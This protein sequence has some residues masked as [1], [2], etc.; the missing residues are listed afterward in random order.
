[1]QHDVVER[2]DAG[3]ARR[4]RRRV[5][6]RCCLARVLAGELRLERRDTARRARACSCRSPTRRS[7]TVSAPSGIS[8]STPFRLCSR[9][10]VSVS[11]RGPR[12]RRSAARG[13]S[14][15]P[16]RYCPVSGLS[17][18]RDIGPAKT[19]LAPLLAARRARAPP[20]NRRRGSPR[21]RARRRAPCCRRRAAA[22]AAR[23]AG[24]CRAGAAR[25][26]ARRARTACRRAASRASSR[27][28][29]A[30][31]RRPRACASRDSA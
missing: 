22:R 28:R 9:A 17:A 24:P 19:T 7:P 4:T 20:C 25:S 1:M 18:T 5:S 30:A 29:C 14:R 16:V 15:A 27:A 10:P 23:A 8:M 21:G 26:T 2:L 12:R 13:S 11:H 3:D 6:P 31:P